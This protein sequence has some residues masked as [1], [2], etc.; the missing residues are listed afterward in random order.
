MYLF[1]RNQALFYQIVFILM[2]WMLYQDP[3]SGTE[4]LIMDGYTD[5]LFSLLPVHFEC[6]GRRGIHE[7]S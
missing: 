3:D 6:M 1:P 7:Y 5:I 2:A 4:M